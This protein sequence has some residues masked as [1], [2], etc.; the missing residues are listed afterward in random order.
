MGSLYLSNKIFNQPKHRRDAEADVTAHPPWEQCWSNPSTRRIVSSSIL[1]F[2]FR[3]AGVSAERL[4]EAFTS[5]PIKRHSHVIAGHHNQGIATSFLIFPFFCM[6]TFWGC[7][8]PH[9][10]TAEVA[11]F[12]TYQP[13]LEIVVQQDVVAEQLEA[14]VVRRHHMLNRQQRLNHHLLHHTLP[15]VQPSLLIYIP[16]DCFSVPGM[17]CR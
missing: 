3:S 1:L 11:T 16:Q 9:K 17:A 14:V 7:L 13:R 2:S 4:G 5:A 12:V 15:N 8:R 6:P 10:A